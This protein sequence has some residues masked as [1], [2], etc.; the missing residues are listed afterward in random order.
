MKRCTRCKQVKNISEFN[1]KYKSRGIRQG[2][3][4]QCAS[5]LI[6]KHYET[7]K[8]YYLRKARIRTKHLRTEIRDYVWSYLKT[9]HCVDCGESD[10]I[11]LE[12]DHIGEKTDDISNMIKYT[13]V[14]RVREEIT[15]CD[16]RCANCHRKITAKRRGWDKQSHALVA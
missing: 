3:C 14:K 9:H 6:R 2:H 1:F 5:L 11:V 8:D 10:P 13:T 15:H 4:R 12:F 16:V 7:H